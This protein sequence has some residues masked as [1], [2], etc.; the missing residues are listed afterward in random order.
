MPALMSDLH[1]IGYVVDTG[2]WSMDGRRAIGHRRRPFP[3]VRRPG[4]VGY[5]EST[6]TPLHA[7]SAEAFSFGPTPLGHTVD[8]T[9]VFPPVISTRIEAGAELD[10]GTPRTFRFPL[11]V[12]L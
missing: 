10:L 4:P 9:A 3:A 7:S 2:V 8:D 1:P 11:G 5:D 6:L 12:D